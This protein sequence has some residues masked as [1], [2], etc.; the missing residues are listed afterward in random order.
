MTTQRDVKAWAVA[1]DWSEEDSPAYATAARIA[2]AM[3]VLE[4]IEA[5]T[6]DM[7]ADPDF[8]DHCLQAAIDA[9]GEG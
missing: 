9:G 7:R 1:A 8:F 3:R 6:D 2:T 5:R 4:V